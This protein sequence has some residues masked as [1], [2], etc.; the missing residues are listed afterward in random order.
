M[1]EEFLNHSNIE[2][3]PNKGFSPNKKTKQQDDTFSCAL[4]NVKK[5][6]TV[7]RVRFE[8][9]QVYQVIN[10]LIDCILV[11]CDADKY[12]NNIQNLYSALYNL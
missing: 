4:W 3:V 10:I 7:R 6:L 8:T 9:I 2:A 12:N 5:L 1:G 11:Y